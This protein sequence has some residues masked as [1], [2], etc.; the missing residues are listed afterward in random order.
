MYPNQ[1]ARSIDTRRRGCLLCGLRP[2]SFLASFLPSSSALSARKEGQ[3][4]R[5]RWRCLLRNVRALY[6]TCRRVKRD[7]PV[8][9]ER[10]KRAALVARFVIYTAALKKKKK[11]RRYD[12][13]PPLL[14]FS[15]EYVACTVEWSVLKTLSVILNTAHFR[16]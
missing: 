13:A 15:S 2:S 6:A 9:R 1:R 11:K 5:R 8:T 4:R 10:C 7:S 3:W 16:Y 14:F 12:H